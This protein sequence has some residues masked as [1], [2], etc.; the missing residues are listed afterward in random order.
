M[1][2][3]DQKQVPADGTSIHL[4]VADLAHEVSKDF[5]G[6]DFI[7]RNEISFRRRWNLK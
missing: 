2:E 6:P 3:W 7:F 4:P 5:A 1:P